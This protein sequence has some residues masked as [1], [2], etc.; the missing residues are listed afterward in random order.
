MRVFWTTNTFNPEVSKLFQMSSPH[1]VSWIEAMSE[2][3]AALPD[4]ELAIACPCKNQTFSKKKYNGI[5]YY[6]VPRHSSEQWKNAVE[7]FGA[8]IIHAYGTEK[9]HNLYLIK[10]VQDRPIVV[11]LQGL[12]S[13]YQRHYY[14]GIDFSDIIRYTPLRDI[15]RASGFI[16][17]RRDY[18]KRSKDEIEILNN[19]AYVEGRSTWDRVMAISINSNLHYYYC[20][21][22]LR[23]AFYNAEKWNYET[24]NKH[25][26]FVPQGVYPIKGLHFA[27]EG[28]HYVKKYY[29]DAKIVATGINMFETH[30]RIKRILYDNGYKRYIN[31]LAEKL[32]LVDSIEF[33]GTKDAQGIAQTLARSHVALVSS[34]IENAPNSIA[35]A[36][37]IGTPCIASFVGGNMDMLEHGNEGFLYCYNEPKMLAEYICQ[38]FSS[39]DLAEKFSKNAINK[40]NERHDPKKL[41][42]TIMG[43]YEDILKDY[44]K[45]E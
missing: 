30:T 14:G 33:I 5:T 21:R 13:E 35:E 45:K 27:I 4:V 38:I 1:A 26:I 19:V 36:M 10:G 15:V 11:S 28:L 44:A 24:V 39:K 41:L 6:L 20:P 40:A 42:L 18:I 8:D 17:G 43:I 29:P 31:D 37:I 7:D 23:R 25:T 34:S 3:L 16:S 2:R 22:M 32:D 9:E 12:V